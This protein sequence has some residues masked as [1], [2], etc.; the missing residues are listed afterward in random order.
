[1]KTIKRYTNMRTAVIYTVGVLAH[2]LTLQSE[3]MVGEYARV[4]PP[5]IED[6]VDQGPSRGAHEHWFMDAHSIAAR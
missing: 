2:R 4:R 6:R 1:M 5:Y 3:A